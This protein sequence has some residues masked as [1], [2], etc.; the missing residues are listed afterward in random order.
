MQPFRR[1]HLY[2]KYM[3]KIEFF[4][5]ENKLDNSVVWFTRVDGVCVSGSMSYNEY[6]A[7]EKYELIRTG[8]H[9]VETLIDSFEYGN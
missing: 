3:K 5:E 6:Q 7:R 1:L 2:N 9:T 4:K 8:K